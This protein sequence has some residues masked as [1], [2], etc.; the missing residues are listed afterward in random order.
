M[1]SFY[2]NSTNIPSIDLR[3]HTHIKYKATLYSYKHT[4]SIEYSI[5]IPHCILKI[6]HKSIR[7]IARDQIHKFKTTSSRHK[8]F[9]VC[10]FLYWIFLVWGY[11]SGTTYSIEGIW[12]GGLTYS[13]HSIKDKMDKKNR[14]EESRRDSLLISSE[15]R[16]KCQITHNPNFLPFFLTHF[17]LFSDPFLVKKTEKY[18]T[19]NRARPENRPHIKTQDP[20]LPSITNQYHRPSTCS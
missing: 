15:F 8:N 11:M 10:T 13:L 4:L 9:K 5:I 2:H 6:F 14:V 1:A 3:S 17:A 7:L 12:C 19:A 16:Q 20:R 18:G